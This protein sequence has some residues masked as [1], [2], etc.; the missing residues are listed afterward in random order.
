MKATDGPPMIF[1]NSQVNFCVESIMKKRARSITVFIAALPIRQY[2]ISK[3]MSRI[4]SPF[5]PCTGRSS[6]IC[7][8]KYKPSRLH[9]VNVFWNGRLT[10]TSR[11]SELE[12]IK[13]GSHRVTWTC[14][15]LTSAGG[16]WNNSR[17]IEV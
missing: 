12:P 17:C 8:R 4:Y 3:S 9:A 5:K 11:F 14:L 1:V 10:S 2:R 13:R 16:D 15:A 6:P 7:T